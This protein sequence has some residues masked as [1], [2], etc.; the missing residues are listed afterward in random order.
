MKTLT[1]GKILNDYQ[2]YL[3]DYEIEQLRKVQRTRTDFSTQVR[4]LKG[5]L[6][7]EEWDFMGDS[8]ADSKDRSRGIN[9]MSQTYIDQI[10][11]KR[12]AFGVRPYYDGGTASDISSDYFCEEVVRH[13]KNYKELLDLKSRKEKQIVFV[14]MD[15][16]L[17][18][19]QSG[20]DRISEEE[21]EKY[22]GNLDEVPGIFSLMEPNDGAIEAYKW[23]CKNF[24]TY[25]LSTAPWNNP[26]AWQDKLHWVKKYLPDVSHK[27]LILSH[28]KHL[29]KGDFLID[30]RTAN[31]AG[32]FIGK[33]IHF[34][35]DG[36]GFDDWR[37]VIAYMK[38]LA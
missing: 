17:V 13:T 36:K 8:I 28:N 15:G 24:D 31:G 30:D 12:K 20:I 18:N 14:D 6:F 11:K 3:S 29:A 2:D 9:P 23:L 38:N 1:I 4:E 16:V 37:A 19:F 27:R 34:K 22:E 10:N 25:I 35:E 5:A 7:G 32:K 21:K 26:S 33:H